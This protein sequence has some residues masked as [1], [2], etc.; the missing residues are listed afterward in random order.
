MPCQDIGGLTDEDSGNEGSGV[1]NPNHLG[2]LN[3][4]AELVTFH[5]EDDYD[6]IMYLS[7][8]LTASQKHMYWQRRED[9]NNALVKEA[10]SRNA[11]DDVMRY[12]HFANITK[13]NK[14]DSFCK[15]AMFFKNI[16][17]TATKYVERT[18]FVSVDKSMIRPVLIGAITNPG[19]GS[20]NLKRAGY[21][22]SSE[23]LKMIEPLWPRPSFSLHGRLVRLACDQVSWWQDQF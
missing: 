13:P 11:F 9:T 10:M 2:I 17:D 15:V 19:N 21:F 3:R 1:K 12:T 6:A 5:Q 18:E 8:Y 23:G 20:W 22:S 16:N 4:Q 14:D 7:G